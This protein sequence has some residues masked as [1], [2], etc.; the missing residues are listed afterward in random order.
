MS[1]T[2]V[3]GEVERCVMQIVVAPLRLG[4]VERVGHVAAGAGMRD[5]ERDVALASSDDDIAIMSPSD[6]ATRD[7]AE[8]EELVIRID[9]QRI[10]CRRRRRCRRGARSPGFHGA[11]EIGVV[12]DFDR[13]AQRLRVGLEDFVLDRGEVVARFDLGIDRRRSVR[14]D[15]A[16]A[17]S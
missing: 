9:R 12:E 13:I 1:E 5:A 4:A 15:R 3:I 10:R 2:L 14:P 11:F 17:R 7:H 16:P 8:F 6:N